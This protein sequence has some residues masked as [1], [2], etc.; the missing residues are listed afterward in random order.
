M[1]R[2]LDDLLTAR[3]L[4]RTAIQILGRKVVSGEQRLK[5]AQDIG[6][7]WEVLAIFIGVSGVDVSDIKQEHTREVLRSITLMRRWHQLYGSEATY[8]KLMHGLMKVGRTDLIESLL[9][10]KLFGRQ[11]EPGIKFWL[12]ILI[13]LGSFMVYFISIT[14]PT[15]SM[16]GYRERKGPLAGD[17]C[18]IPSTTLND[19]S[20]S[21]IQPMESRSH[22]S[23][24]SAT[25]CN[26]PGFDLPTIHH[27]D[28]F[29][30]REN[31]ISMVVSMMANAHI[32][33]INGAPGIGKS[34]LAIR[35][36]Y[37][38]LRN[39]TSV[40]YVNMGEKISLFKESMN[41]NERFNSTKGHDSEQTEEI[42]SIIEIDIQSLQVVHFQHSNKSFSYDKSLSFIQELR[43]WIGNIRCPTVLIL[44]NC[45]D[46]LVS[47]SRDNFINLIYSLIGQSQLHV[48]IV[49][50]QKLILLESFR[51]WI[52]SNL[53]VSASVYFLDQLVMPV[54]NSSYL[55]AVA[56]LV[57][58]Y[59][60][61]L[62]IVGK[63]LNLHGEK[64][65]HEIHDIKEELRKNPLNFLDKA[66]IQKEKF[67]PVLDV[68]FA[69]L[70]ELK[71]CGYALGLFPGSFDKNAG[72]AVTS[73]KCFESYTQHSLLDEYYLAYNQ[74]YQMH[75][76][77]REYVKEKVSNASMMTFNKNFGR[78]YQKFLLKFTMKANLNKYDEHSL[79]LETHNF[80]FL[81]NLLMQTKQKS[82]KQLAIIAFL[83]SENLLKIEELYDYFDLYMDKL[84]DVCRILRPTTCGSFYSYAVKYL[85]QNCKCE[86]L[87]EYM[88]NIFH[89]SCMNNFD[90][91]VV[92]QISTLCQKSR[93]EVLCTQLS[94]REERFIERVLYACHCGFFGPFNTKLILGFIMMITSAFWFV[95]SSV[96]NNIM[97]IPHSIWLILL[98]MF[99]PLLSLNYVMMIHFSDCM[100]LLISIASTDFKFDLLNPL[101]VQEV[102]KRLCVT[103][104]ISIIWFLLF[105]CTRREYYKI[106]K[107]VK[108]THIFSCV[109]TSSLTTF[110]VL[111]ICKIQFIICHFLPI[112][113]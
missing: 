9:G 46:I 45:D 34:T 30:G 19:E 79:S 31:D 82:S 81:K 3:G 8:L 74:R 59:P 96:F 112:C 35:V 40:R 103:V 68:A 111:Y 25:E 108:W 101:I 76:L 97:K 86:T 20:S 13:V 73:A 100:V 99:V 88:L 2:S 39:G 60:L 69:R 29:V 51:Y 47:A 110:I 16:R 63:L 104:S 89:S 10:D 113:L 14:H 44:D 77:I 15:L 72:M 58:G 17:T 24:D 94:Y 7:D 5:I 64:V 52:V 42:K 50:T 107:E 55:V 56:E 53:S 93:Y 1:T 26:P 71:D 95:C 106:Q 65:V 41:S 48:I 38:L 37:E 109:I 27:D 87:S 67:R 57:E 102:N 43:N 22:S 12:V 105:L 33:N 78:Y 83:V 23:N 6:A 90:C 66:T 92:D 80:D 70:G 32:I 11:F 28:F 36:G 49:S 62:K 75:R 54:I 61:A 21:Y 85:Y 98:C 18:T 4:S 84:G 91:R